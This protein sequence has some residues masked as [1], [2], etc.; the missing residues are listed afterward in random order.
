MQRTLMWTLKQLNLSLEQYGREQMEALGISPTQGITLHHLLSR[1]DQMVYAVD[2]HEAL[3]LSKSAVSDTLKAL[4]QKGY[5]TMTVNP[6][7]DRKKQIVLTDKAYELEDKLSASL[8]EQQERLCKTIS[9][10]RLKQ[11][12]ADLEI[13][14]LNLTPEDNQRESAI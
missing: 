10:Q 13:M 4:K 11:L 7:D 6:N 2:L 1:K 12:K 9:E 5:L 3:G 14:L 8:R